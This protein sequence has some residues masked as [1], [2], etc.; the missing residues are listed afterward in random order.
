MNFL[1]IK[2]KKKM[3]TWIDNLDKK[4][5]S[6]N[7]LKKIIKIIINKM[8]IV[9]NQSKRI[10]IFIYIILMIVNSTSK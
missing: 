10:Q 4:I 6:A 8:N 7:V 5:I 3:K 1:K 2:R 9:I